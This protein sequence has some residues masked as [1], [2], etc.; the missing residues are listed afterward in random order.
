MGTVLS[1]IRW[2]GESLD[3]WKEAAAFEE[4]KHP[5]DEDGK[6]A[7]SGQSGA[8][9]D[10]KE[11]EKRAKQLTKMFGTDTCSK[12]QKMTEDTVSNSTPAI[13]RSMGSLEKII[14]DGRFK[15]ATEIGTSGA[16]SQD[17]KLRER[18]EKG[19]F[20]YGKE[21][22]SVEQRPI[23]GFLKKS[24]N[25]FDTAS[26]YGKGQMQVELKRDAFMDRGTFTIGDSLGFA[27]SKMQ[28]QPSK[29]S[30]PSF[31]SFPITSQLQTKD[32]VKEALERKALV[33]EGPD[34]YIECQFHGLKAK[35]IAHV[36]CFVPPSDKIRRW[37]KANGV[38]ITVH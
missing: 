1:A 11:H 4:A 28:T 37:A 21:L 10:E 20:A 18:A 6:F 23:Y 8:P 5:R 14:D 34:Q 17:L 38:G 33:G 24:K 16:H 12:L 36:H 25:D 35:D 3:A 32:R 9:T 7:Q 19:L 13:W 31:S 15:S 22:P 26:W 27:G 30:A 29:A 2:I